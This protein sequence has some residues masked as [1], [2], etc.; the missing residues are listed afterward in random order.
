ML[1]A[2]GVTSE[3]DL[4]QTPPV[5]DDRWA[6]VLTDA[7][8]AT[9]PERAEAEQPAE[10]AQAAKA[11]P[12]ATDVVNVTIPYMK[13]RPEVE[14]ENAEAWAEY[15]ACGDAPEDTEALAAETRAMF[16]ERIQAIEDAQQCV[17]LARQRFQQAL[18]QLAR[19]LHYEAAGPQPVAEAA[20]NESPAATNE[21]PPVAHAI[22]GDWRKTRLAAAG[23]PAGACEV[24]AANPAGEILTLGDLA[25]R[26]AVNSIVPGPDPLLSVPKIGQAK[27]DRIMECCLAVPQFRE[28]IERQRQ[29]AT[30]TDL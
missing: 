23:V 2:T 3:T 17:D 6:D 30:G 26:F 7:S 4:G 20:T 12:P 11:L 21:S 19:V 14:A 24:L 5:Q 18:R 1:D 25:D 10:T 8:K 9:G 29:P 28:A 27:R 15:A 13:T 16:A 22:E